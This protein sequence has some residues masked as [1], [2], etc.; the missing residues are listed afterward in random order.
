MSSLAKRAK[1]AHSSTQIGRKG[2][3][4]SNHHGKDEK[5]F[6]QPTE[7]PVVVIP[8][9][10]SFRPVKIGC[11]SDQTPCSSTASSMESMRGHFGDPR[12]A[13]I[14]QMVHWLD[15]VNDDNVRALR[16]R[17]AFIN[18]VYLR[19]N[20]LLRRLLIVID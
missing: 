16:P 10:A 7:L 15:Y 5:V 1:P 9:D 12:P 13:H 4:T 11:L 19:L 6:V 18:D 2:N 3:E 14:L 17:I 8:R 20:W